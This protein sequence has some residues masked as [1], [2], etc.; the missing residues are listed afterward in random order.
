MIIVK[1]IGGMGNQ[2][3]QY[4]AGRRLAMKHNTRLKL[5]LTSLLDRTPYDNFIYRNYELD[6]FNIQGNFASP[7]EINKFYPLKKNIFYRIRKKLKHI[8]LVQEPHFHF[9]DKTLSAPNNTYMEGYWQSEKYFKDIENIIRDEY[10]IKHRMVG[11]NEQMAKEIKTCDS[12]SIHIRRGDYVSNLVTN[13]KHG[14]CPV[15]YYQKAVKKIESRLEKP[16][17]YIFSD[18]PKWAIENLNLEYPTKFITH[19]SADK[20]Y[21]DLR[22]MSLCKHN[23]IANSSFS[24]WGGWLNTNSE[25]IV[26]VP[27]KWFNDPSINTDDLIPERWIRI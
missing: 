10:K 18:D 7:S 25:K 20:N 9:Y 21:E 15:E 27:K 2:M 22:L 14:V 16:Q 23:I 8:N 19:N 24:W 13:E 5:D 26:I 12:V 11:L 6:V 3:F 1:L 4:A 17:F